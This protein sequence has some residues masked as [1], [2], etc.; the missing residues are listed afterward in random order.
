[1]GS[2]LDKIVLEKNQLVTETK[3]LIKKMYLHDNDPWII[4]YSGGKDSTLTTQIVIDTLLEM[5]NAGIKLEKEVH[6][7]SSDTL[8]ETPLIIKTIKDTLNGIK[9]LGIDK[10]IPLYSSTVMPKYDQTFWVNIIGRGYPTPNQ[11][12]RWCTDRM[13]IDPANRFI[14]KMVG[15]HGK[16]IMVLGVRDGE[17]TIRDGVLDKHTVENKV[18]LKH[19]TLI[20]TYVFAPIRKFTVDDVW[21]Y[22]LNTENPWGGDNY[23]LYQLYSESSSGECPLV[24][25]Q[26]IKKEAG[27]CGNSRFG[28]WTCTV[29][30]EDKSLT[31][32]IN[33]GVN[34]LRPLLEYRN[35]L[36]SI[37]D[38]D[39][40]RMKRRTNGSLYFLK[41]YQ[42]TE[43]T[44]VLPS[45]GDRKKLLI[46]RNESGFWIDSMDREW[47]LFNDPLTS[48]EDCKKYIIE[49]NIDLDS[50]EPP[51]I[52][53]KN[54]D[55]SYS[56]L[57]TGP[58]TMDARKLILEK[59][60]ETEKNLPNKYSLIRNEEL[61]EIKKIWEELGFVDDEVQ[62][63]YQKVYGMNFFEYEN[64][65]E[66]LD[67]ED[68][69]IIEKIST[70]NEI[71]SR[72]IVKLLKISQNQLGYIN[73]K[74]AIKQINQVFNSEVNRVRFTGE[75]D[76]N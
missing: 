58:F 54:I 72:F 24:I 1:M 32:F 46:K 59:L 64:D 61:I 27:S 12:F 75:E 5:S 70:N 4:G 14:E 76:D 7:I 42:L 71:D 2:I 23:E 3:V 37:R 69:K 33:N 20:N 11:T 68:V 15:K 26:N 25:D 31:G 38:I 39:S 56:K 13:K 28:C 73:R 16:A 62:G 6:V 43:D 66:L 55:E 65:I 67:S 29:V 60:L 48:Q 50:G 35:W 34:W 53:I 49:N 19:S 9:K 22:L 41:L 40:Y 18:F 45:K 47:I 44:L 10:K 57:G 21:N 52:L 30:S 17:S 36:A 63:I 51:L 74:E 8:V